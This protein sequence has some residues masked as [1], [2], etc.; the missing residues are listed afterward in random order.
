ML[1][2]IGFRHYLYRIRKANS[3]ICDMCNSGEDD[4]AEHTL[5]NCHRYEEERA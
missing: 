4:T 3:P 1:T 5:F 2:G